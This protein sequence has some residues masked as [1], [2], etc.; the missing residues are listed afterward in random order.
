MVDILF[1]VAIVAKTRAGV[2]GK[3]DSE[4]GSKDDA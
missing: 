4:E 1:F 2:N 3:D